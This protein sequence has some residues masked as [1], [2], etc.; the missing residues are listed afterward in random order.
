MMPVSLDFRPTA[1]LWFIVS[2]PFLTVALL[3][4]GSLWGLWILFTSHLLL[5]FC[6]LVPTLRQFGPVITK[7]STPARTVWLTIDD[8]PDPQTTPGVLALLQKHG[9]RA[10]FFLI[11]TKAAKYPDL[12]HMILKAGHS[13]GNHTQTH[14]K[15]SFWR[16]GPNKLARE[17]DGFESTLSSIGIPPPIWFRAPVGMKNPFLHPI[18]AARGLGLVAW[19]ARAFDTRTDDTAKIVNRIKRS[20]R[21][22]AIIL[23]HEAQNPDVC[24]NALDKLLKELTAEQFRIII[25]KPAELLAGRSPLPSKGLEGIAS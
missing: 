21:S 1:T 5:V 3:A 12:T 16:L 14:P 6:T 19:S 13:I 18:L 9:A 15:Y 7:Y 8:G 23:F 10:T 11:G 25:P 2:A 24:L 4:T 20:V 17:I 22:G